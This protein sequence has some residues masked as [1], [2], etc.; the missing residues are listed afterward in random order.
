MFALAT[1]LRS[2]TFISLPGCQTTDYHTYNR[3]LHTPWEKQPDPD[4]RSG[5]V[6]L[7]TSEPQPYLGSGSLAPCTPHRLHTSFTLASHFPHTS[8]S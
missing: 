4:L 7:N 2:Y 1:K 8:F 5:Q 3:Q 6:V